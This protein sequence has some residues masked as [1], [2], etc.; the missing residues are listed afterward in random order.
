MKRRAAGS[1][2]R[3]HRRAATID[4]YIGLIAR[5]AKFRAKQA[6]IT[7]NREERT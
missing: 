2:A 3:P 4:E 6:R 5:V 7:D 1:A